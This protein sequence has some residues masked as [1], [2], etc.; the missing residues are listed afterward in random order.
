MSS[1]INAF[2]PYL[3]KIFCTTVYKVNVDAGFTCP[4]RDGTV[5]TTGLA[6]GNN[7]S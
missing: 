5:A 2:G 7:E 6:G 3:K 4:N 1:R